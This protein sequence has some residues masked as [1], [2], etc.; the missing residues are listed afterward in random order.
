MFR[1]LV[2]E[3]PAPVCWDF[4]FMFIDNQM[5]LLVQGKRKKKGRWES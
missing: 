5:E 1:T 2:S 3:V 4:I